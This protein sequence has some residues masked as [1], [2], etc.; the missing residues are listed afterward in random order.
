MM[1]KVMKPA[2]TAIL[3]VSILALAGCGTVKKTFGVGKNPPDEFLVMRKR[4]LV[5]PPD[6]HLRP[7]E[8]G[9]PTPQDVPGARQ[10]VEAL[11]PDRPPTMVEGSPG[12]QALLER[13]ANAS[14]SV[15]SQVANR[16]EIV[17]EKGLLLPDILA[18]GEREFASDGSTIDRVRSEPL[19]ERP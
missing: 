16:E 11:F 9:Q 7:P 17:V 8:A 2:V 10:V 13:I 1:F 12:E 19:D 15:R 6:Y 18:V 14:S 3:T 4:P 5:I